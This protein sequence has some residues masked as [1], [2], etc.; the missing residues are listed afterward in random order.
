MTAVEVF[1]DRN[2]ESVLVGR[3]HFTRMRGRISTTFL[4]DPDYL[5]NGG[6]SIDPALPL[7]S[8]AQH[9]EGLTV[10][11]VTT[12]RL[13]RQSGTF[14]SLRKQTT[15][16]CLSGSSGQLPCAIPTTISATMDSWLIADPGRSARFSM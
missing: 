10:I 3:A 2:G 4:Y 14:R 15:R 13:L 7:V 9:Q 12:S 16:S 11:T 1:L 5:V 8:G 6:T